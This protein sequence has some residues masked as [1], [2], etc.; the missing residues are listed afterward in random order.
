[1][2]D[3]NGNSRKE[4]RR[5]WRVDA[6]EGTQGRARMKG[7]SDYGEK[8]PAPAGRAQKREEITQMASPLHSWA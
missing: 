6:N 4:R 7:F 2:E 5:A 3:T 1:M 8:D